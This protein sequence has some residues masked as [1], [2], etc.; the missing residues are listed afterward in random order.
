V[1]AVDDS[2]SKRASTLVSAVFACCPPG[3][4]ERE[5]RSSIS[6]SGTVTER[7]TRRVSDRMGSSTS[8]VSQRARSASGLRVQCPPRAGEPT[9]SLV[10]IRIG[11][12]DDVPAYRRLLSIAL[13]IEPDLEV[14]GEAA[15]GE[16]AV[17]LVRATRPDVLL[18]DVAMPDVDGLEALPR[19][20][21]A[22]PGTAVIFVS[23]FTNDDL[24][25]RALSGGAF[26][27]L[28]KGVTP[29]EIAQSVREAAR[30]AVA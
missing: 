3:P 8:P 7:V 25:M 17:E 18:L 24:R 10:T 30:T 2:T 16:E 12:C 4:L 9:T 13:G 20:R 23:G 26:R 6:A 29:Q 14:V 15:T 22:S 11:I 1:S 28:V 21:A 19:V 27:Y 5:N